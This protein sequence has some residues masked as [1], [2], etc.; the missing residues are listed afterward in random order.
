[1]GSALK[2]RRRL[3]LRWRK[4]TP[5]GQ[6]LRPRPLAAQA[7]RCP[8]GICWGRRARKEQWAQLGTVSGERDESCRNL[9]AW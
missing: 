3:C 5:G 6:L 9:P 1:M 2:P 4:V 8:R 7:C